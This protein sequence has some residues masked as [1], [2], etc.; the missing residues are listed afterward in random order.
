MNTD[1]KKKQGKRRKINIKTVKKGKLTYTK[2]GKSKVAIYKKIVYLY[3]HR[4]SKI[5]ESTYKAQ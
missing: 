5:V 1:E 4:Q 2:K 3:I